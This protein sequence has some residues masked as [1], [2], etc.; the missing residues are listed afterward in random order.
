MEVI[1]LK[2]SERCCLEAAKIA[3]KYLKD[4]DT[5]VFGLPTGSSPLGFY[6]QLIR[7]HQEEGLSF[8][9][10]TSYNLDEYVGI[11]THH[12]ASYCTFMEN[13][14]FKYIDADSKNLHLPNGMANDIVKECSDY[15]E[16]ISNG[17]G[18]DLQLLG[19]GGNGHIAFNEPGSSLT[20]RTRVKTL[21]DKT[22]QDN[23][24]AFESL[25]HV[26]M[27][28]IT[29]GVGTIMETRHIVVLAFGAD[30]SEAVANMV[31]GPITSSCPASIL[32]MHPRA[33][34]IIDEAASIDLARSDYY[35]WVYNNRPHW[36]RS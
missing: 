20:S 19:I 11:G 21:T 29:M 18:I 7:M 4:L 35:K 34:I 8:K 28:V 2:N 1:I 13:N 25:D 27:H 14:F 36:Q 26:P 9:G 24:S 6:R 30:K 33:T 17:G 5:P 32:Q 3:V 10:M 16:M 23:S 31:E 12:P 15:E 22:R